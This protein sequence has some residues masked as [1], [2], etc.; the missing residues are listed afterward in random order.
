MVA[1]TLSPVMAVDSTAIG[2]NKAQ[3][4]LVCSVSSLS[5][6][7]NRQILI[8][9]ITAYREQIKHLNIASVRMPAKCC[10]APVLKRG[11]LKIVFSHSGD[12]FRHQVARL[13]HT[14]LRKRSTRAVARLF[15]DKRHLNDAK[16]PCFRPGSGARFEGMGL[17]GGQGWIFE[18]VWFRLKCSRDWLSEMESRI[19]RLMKSRCKHW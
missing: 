15:R 7:R 10:L 6:L 11:P 8:G 19:F 4:R 2:A 12:A 13:R 9:R 17:L 3:D 1:F 16:P 5:C 14:L 18:K